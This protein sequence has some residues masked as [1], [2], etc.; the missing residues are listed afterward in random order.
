MNPSLKWNVPLAEI[1][2]SDIVKERMYT[3]PP[4]VLSCSV[5]KPDEILFNAIYFVMPLCT[6]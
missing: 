2:E 5:S 6:I 4:W 1:V 3:S